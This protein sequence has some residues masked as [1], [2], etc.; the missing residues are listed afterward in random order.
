MTYKLKKNTKQ[1]LSQRSNYFGP[2]EVYQFYID[3]AK[4]SGLLVELIAKKS[5]TKESTQQILKV[6][7]CIGGAYLGFKGA[8]KIVT[9]RR[10]HINNN[11]KKLKIVR[12]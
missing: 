7:G 6:I 11:F 12:K 4:I 2:E 3:S 9:Y 1:A 10:N 5:G 8:S